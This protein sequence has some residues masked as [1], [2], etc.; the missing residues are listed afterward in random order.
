MILGLVLPFGSLKARAGL[1]VDSDGTQ[2]LF[3]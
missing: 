1:L 3:R 2:G